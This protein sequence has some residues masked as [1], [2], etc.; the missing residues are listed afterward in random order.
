MAFFSVFLAPRDFIQ[1]V[2]LTRM[3]TCDPSN[4]KFQI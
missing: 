2:I 3:D 1:Q 4:N